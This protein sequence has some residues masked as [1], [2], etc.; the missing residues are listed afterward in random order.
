MK[1]GEW[2]IMNVTPS[3]KIFGPR[4]QAAAAI[5]A[6]ALTG[7]LI[8]QQPLIA[9]LIVA[10]LVILA[11]IRYIDLL[12]VAM[13]WTLPYM[14]VNLPTGA[15][16]FKLSDVL[17][18]LL[19][20]AVVARS[21]LQ[22]KPLVMPPPTAQVLVYVA[23]LALSV[24]FAPPV[25]VPYTGGAPNL[26]LTSSQ[27]R[28]FGQILWACLSWMVVIGLYN[29]VG[30]SAKLLKRCV[31]AHILASGLAM[32]V[33][34]LMLALG[35]AGMTF[36]SAGRDLLVQHGGT[37]RLAGVAYEP[38]FLGFYLTTAIPVTLAVMLFYP[39]W[40]PRRLLQFILVLQ[41]IV[42]LCTF[43]TGAWIS[44]PLALLCMAPLWRGRRLPKH[45][46]KA[47]GVFAVIAVTLSASVLTALPAYQK[48]LLMTVNKILQGGDV[49]RLNELT[50]G[51]GMI[52][53]YPIFGVG[54][55]MAGFHMPRYHPVIVSQF[56]DS[57]KEITPLYADIIAETG[58]VG[59]LAVAWCALTGLAVILKTIRRRGAV[60]TPIL[61]ALTASLIG[62]AI[63]YCS[64]NAIYLIFFPAL[65]GL[66][67]SAARIANASPD[68]WTRLESEPSPT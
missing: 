6:L 22:R 25:P 3:L 27:L 46:L 66:A 56:A 10:A 11:S 63:D 26:S 28:S 54:T 35:A 68:T 24:V 41:L 51:F 57:Y 45:L 20:A 23:V 15:F 5:I 42:L 53:D 14:V 55:G 52:R 19:G 16:K 32:I 44:I 43:S 37:F 4:S 64:I 13:F 30:D 1:A 50:A 12:A 47:L 9:A 67:L 8:A 21:L 34:L 2:P 38:L 61:T 18:Y 31:C 40:L 48:L 7:A 58:V 36:Y 33:S 65:I 17:A 29:V 60:Q 59:F 49:M 39:D 62:C